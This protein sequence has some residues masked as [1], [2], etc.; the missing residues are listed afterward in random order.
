MMRKGL[1]L[2]LIVPFVVNAQN[3]GIHFEKDL[4]WSDIKLKA[5]S[6]HKY[7]FLDCFATWC[8]P[9]K[10]MDKSVYPQAG[11]GQFFNDSFVS[12]K[13]QMDTTDHDDQTTKNWYLAAHNIAKD[14][15]VSAFPTFLFFSPEGQ[16]VHR[17]FGYVDEDHFISFGKNALNPSKQYYTLL[18]SYKTGKLQAGELRDL[19]ILAKSFGQYH[20]AE[21]IA[22]GYL[23][24]LKM[25]EVYTNENI[26]YLRDFTQGSKDIGFFTFYKHS[27]KVDSIMGSATYAEDLINYIIAKEEIDP[28]LGIMNKAGTGSPN[29]DSL[30]KNVKIKYSAGYAIRAVVEG[31][32]R[33]YGFKKNWVELTKALTTK[34]E[35][36]QGDNMDAFNL[37]NDCWHIF[38][39]S[40]DHHE[41]TR[42]LYWMEALIQHKKDAAESAADVDTYANLLYKLGKNK[43]ALVWEE[44]ARQLD[45]S[46][47]QVQNALNK[48]KAGLPTWSTE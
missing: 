33:W 18:E 48:M 20:M 44:K 1:F 10:N 30:A 2:L 27:A 41:L 9:C 4:S 11:V 14:Y 38:Q 12:V 43:E 31:K 6:E 39:Y 40:S 46:D 42:A 26:Q 29:W 23:A 37:D 28:T 21:Q 25:D 3:T 32:I 34:L 15:E 16:L 45:V 36:T 5:K 8:G 13:V 22:S 24:T 17:A 7:I 19:A 35:V 47:A